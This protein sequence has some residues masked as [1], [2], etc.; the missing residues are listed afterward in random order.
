[1]LTSITERITPDAVSRVATRL[2]ESDAA[3][4]RGLPVAVASVLA[5]LVARTG[6]S[7]IMRRV[8]D[9]ATSRDNDINAPADFSSSVTRAMT[10][11]SP[12][13]ALGGGG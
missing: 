13:S 2:G 7:G 12:G 9:L 4:S 1:M 10:T 11:G 5:S 6:D 8:F 3:V